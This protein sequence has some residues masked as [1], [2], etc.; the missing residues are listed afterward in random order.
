MQCKVFEIN[1]FFV[2]EYLK[3][4]YQTTIVLILWATVEQILLITLLEATLRFPCS[5]HHMQQIRFKFFFSPL[6]LDFL[7]SFSLEPGSPV[8]SKLISSHHPKPPDRRH[9]L[10]PKPSQPRETKME[11]WTLQWQLTCHRNAKAEKRLNIWNST[12]CNLLFSLCFFGKLPKC[13]QKMSFIVLIW[14]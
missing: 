14:W 2:R 13:R 10:A 3:S 12:S 5:F 9:V 1:F 4:C 6:R 11:W 7:I 8:K